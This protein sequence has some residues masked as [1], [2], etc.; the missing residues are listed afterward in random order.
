MGTSTVAI[1]IFVITLLGAH[2]GSA[3]ELQATSERNRVTVGDPLP[4]EFS[5]HVDP[6]SSLVD[7]VPRPLDSLP[8]GLR[9]LAVDSFTS[10]PSGEVRGGL[11]VAFF[12]PG[13]QTV[14]PF[15]LV[16]RTPGGGVDSAL[17]QPVSVE[18]TPVLPPGDQELK[19]VR[20]FAPR[21]SAMRLDFWVVLA[22]GTGLL[23]LAFW[24]HRRRARALEGSGPPKA[25]PTPPSAYE[26]ALLRLSEL[27]AAGWSVRGDV[28]RH[29]EGVTE[30][31]R[32]YLEDVGIAALECTTTELT[33][34]LPPALSAD[35]RRERCRELFQQADL[36]KFAG[37]RPSPE[38]AQQFLEAGR[39]LLAE[40]Y[41]ALPL[42]EVTSRAAL[43]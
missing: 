9:V 33:W 5:G 40:W 30:A 35:G 7:R 24:R 27:E 36:V 14:P 10:S 41:R 31:L 42:E 21:H 38:A 22:A 32:R 43:R 15:A 3:Q 12:Q 20:E 17:S 25:A 13:T 26:R 34:S 23:A 4:V 19:D 37:L 18:V 1:V 39:W 2:P 28:L 16:Y 8:G 11:R 6:G 29:Y